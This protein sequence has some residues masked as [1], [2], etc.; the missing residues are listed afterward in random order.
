[1]P[2]FLLWIAFLIP[3]ILQVSPARDWLNHFFPFLWPRYNPDDATRLDEFQIT[4]RELQ[5]TGDNF[6]TRNRGHKTLNTELQARLV[7]ARLDQTKNQINK[8][9]ELVGEIKPDDAIGR[10]D[11]SDELALLR[12]AGD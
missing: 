8:L 3:V 6:Q 5:H 1:M 11:T 12:S 9:T 10:R 2:G 4:A 7:Q